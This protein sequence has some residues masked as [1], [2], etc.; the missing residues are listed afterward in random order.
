MTG[1]LDGPPFK[2]I[3]VEKT[4][5][6]VLACRALF[7]CTAAEDGYHGQAQDGLPTRHYPWV[8]ILIGKLFVGHFQL[9]LKLIL[10]SVKSR[11][12]QIVPFFSI[13]T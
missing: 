2:V 11:L 3:T 5:P 12:L 13:P 4:N 8:E 9:L 6:A 1:N 10:L 7:N